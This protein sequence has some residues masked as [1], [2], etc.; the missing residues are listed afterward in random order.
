MLSIMMQMVR[1]FLSF[2]VGEALGL[3]GW[4]SVDEGYCVCGDCVLGV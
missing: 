4:G 2:L 3:M 1:F